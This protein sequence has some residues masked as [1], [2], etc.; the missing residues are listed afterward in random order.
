[1][2]QQLFRKK[3][4][5]RVS[6]PEQLNEYIRVANPG[7]WMILAAIIVLLVGVCAW[8]ILGHLDTTLSVVAVSGGGE[9]A[10]Y[11]R[12][13]EIGSVAQGMPVRLDGMEYTVAEIATAPVT[14]G[15]GFTDYTLHVGNLQRGEWVYEVAL[16]G[17]APEGVYRAEIV[18]ESVSPMS[19]VMN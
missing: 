7:I 13:A 3:S 1:M 8:G 16:S 5:E 19:F 9:T 4:I 14:V 10:V 15:D 11:V 6:S 2:N 17:A 12:E 18:V